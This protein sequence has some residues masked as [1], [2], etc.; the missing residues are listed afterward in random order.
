MKKALI[1]GYSGLIKFSGRMTVGAF[2]IFAGV[3]IALNILAYTFVFA[4]FF[5]RFATNAAK[6]AESNPEDVTIRQ[7]P[8]SYSVSIEGNHPDL[9]PD[10]T[11]YFWSTGLL[12]LLLFLL[13]AAAA[14]RR[15]HDTGRS[16]VWTLLPVPFLI[17]GMTQMPDLFAQF[18]SRVGDPPM[19]QFALIFANNM[20]YMLCL[21]VVGVMLALPGNPDANR[22][23]PP[24]GQGSEG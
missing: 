14:T 3:N 22:F 13:T 6:V 5:Q 24:P 19:G 17:F 4:A 16:G 1:E 15:L 10:M 7:G 12:A 2:W 11:G 21:V 20:I 8:G 9:M 18:G 23:G